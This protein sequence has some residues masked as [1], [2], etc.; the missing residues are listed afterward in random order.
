MEKFQN[1]LV[2]RA[3][4]LKPIP[5]YRLRRTTGNC[6]TIPYKKGR[7]SRRQSCSPVV[8]QLRQEETESLHVL[9]SVLLSS[10]Q[11]DR[12]AS[13]AVY[14]E[15]LMILYSRKNGRGKQM[16]DT[17]SR[18]V[19]CTE[20]ELTEKNQLHR[21]TLDQLRLRAFPQLTWN[22]LAVYLTA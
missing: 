18:K 3:Q 2:Q 5:Q 4:Y 16:R 17:R 14:R 10:C 7:T 6:P 1:D 21:Q 19:A 12:D 8:D 20:T 22:Q 15:T 11:T 13:S 9:E